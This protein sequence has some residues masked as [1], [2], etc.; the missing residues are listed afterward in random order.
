M[1]KRFS[2]GFQVLANYLFSK[3]IERRSRLNDTDPLLEKRIS[4]D[5]CPQRFVFSLNWDLPFGNRRAIGSGAPRG[6][7]PVISG[8]TVKTIY[9]VQPGGPLGWGNVI[10]YGGDLNLDPGRIDGAFDVT[11]FNRNSQQQLGSNI[12]TFPSQFSTLRRDGVHNMDFSV[13][14]DNAITERMNL[15]FRCEFF[16]FLNSPSFNPPIPRRRTRGLVLLRARRTWRGA[17]KWRSVR[18]GDMKTLALIGLIP[19]LA[20]GQVKFRETPGKI[21]ISIDGKPFSNLY[22]GPTG[23][24]RSCTRCAASRAWWSPAATRSNRSRVRTGTTTGTTAC[25][26]RTATSTASISGATWVRRKPAGWW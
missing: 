9:T 10:Y 18:Y 14:K 12:R 1:E 17:P 19:L 3:L 2:D 11:R 25:G 7:R 20:A 23:P 16:R 8:W 13:I 21:E 22:Y 4:S 5:D 26:T 15:Q 6:L 24:S